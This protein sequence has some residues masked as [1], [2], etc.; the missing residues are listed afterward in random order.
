M[1]IW[2]PSLYDGHELWKAQQNHWSDF[3]FGKINLSTCYYQPSMKMIWTTHTHRQKTSTKQCVMVMQGKKIGCVRKKKWKKWMPI[4]GCVSPSPF[5]LFRCVYKNSLSKTINL[6]IN[7]S[8]KMYFKYLL[9]GT[10]QARKHSLN[11]WENASEWKLN[12]PYSMM[13]VSENERLFS[14]Q[15][16]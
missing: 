1:A 6:T 5:A 7:I 14:L 8:H 15:S 16:K 3:S 13:C 4:L 2:D 9:Y 10:F 11:L 12:A